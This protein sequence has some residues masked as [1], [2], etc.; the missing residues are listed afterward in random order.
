M[1]ARVAS[2]DPVTLTQVQVV[3]KRTIAPFLQL[4]WHP[5]SKKNS[6]LITKVNGHSTERQNKMRG[7]SIESQTISVK[8]FLSKPLRNSTSSQSA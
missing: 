8:F 5:Q 6:L 3:F 2:F 4:L 7:I 1:P